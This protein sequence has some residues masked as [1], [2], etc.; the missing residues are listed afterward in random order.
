[1]KTEERQVRLKPFVVLLTKATC[2]GRCPY[3]INPTAAGVTVAAPCSTHRL[4][5]ATPLA[6]WCLPPDSKLGVISFTVDP[7][8]RELGLAATAEAKGLR[9]SGSG[10]EPEFR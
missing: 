5:L 8:F 1:M 3:K 6:C 2:R 10:L 4:S 9:S 7:S